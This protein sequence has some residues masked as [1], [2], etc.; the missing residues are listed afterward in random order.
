MAMVTLVV[1]CP[2]AAWWPSVRRRGLRET[3][4]AL[5]LVCA[6]T[7]GCLASRVLQ[8]RQGQHDVLLAAILLPV[9]L[10]LT[11]LVMDARHAK[12]GH[13]EPPVIGT[14]SVV[15]FTLYPMIACLWAGALYW[16]GSRA[17]QIPGIEQLSLPAGLSTE[18]GSQSCATGLCRATYYVSSPA[19]PDLSAVYAQLRS[20]LDHGWDLDSHGRDC[21]PT[22]WITDRTLLCVQLQPWSNPAGVSLKMEYVQPGQNPWPGS[23][24]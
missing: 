18:D 17:E 6:V 12:A 10:V 13:R 16:T 23:A 2:L 20:H 1:L 9:P 4:A 22:E 5:L 24:D 21:H 19:E 8:L 15:V 11:G 14:A 7:A 3:V